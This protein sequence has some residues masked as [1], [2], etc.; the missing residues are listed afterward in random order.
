METSL[1]DINC[2]IAA[3]GG[4]YVKWAIDA[5]SAGNIK[6]TGADKTF[7]AWERQAPKDASSGWIEHFKPIFEYFTKRTPGSFITE[8]ENT[9]AWQYQD[10]DLEHA[11]R[12]SLSLQ[13]ALLEIIVGW[14]VRLVKR[15]HCVEL[16][17]FGVFKKS[18]IAEFCRRIKHQNPHV[19]P[20]LWCALTGENKGDSGVFSYLKTEFS[21]LWKLGK[22]SAANAL[23]LAQSHST[24]NSAVTNQALPNIRCTVDLNQSEANYY[25]ENASDLQGLLVACTD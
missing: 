24:E 3:E 21:E 7:G 5:P 10:A 11:E 1:K 6:L 17:L 14:R 4:F 16:R 12:N 25:A 15:S 13:S 19:R 2:S 22:P 18:I 23:N 20:A 9:L 8:T